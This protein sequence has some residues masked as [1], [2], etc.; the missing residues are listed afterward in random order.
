[1]FSHGVTFV[2]N[3]RLKGAFNDFN[4]TYLIEVKYMTII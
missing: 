2:K 4:G 1:M 3:S